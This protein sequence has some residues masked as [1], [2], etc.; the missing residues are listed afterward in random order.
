MFADGTQ[1]FCGRLLPQAG[2]TAAT[3]RALRS[4]GPSALRP[5]HGV[6]N[7]WGPAALVQRSEPVEEAETIGWSLCA[8]ARLEGVL[9]EVLAAY[10]QRVMMN[11]NL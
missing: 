9:E 5:L 8:P 2:S 10:D 4:L 3:Q 1:R 11:T 7:A 6:S